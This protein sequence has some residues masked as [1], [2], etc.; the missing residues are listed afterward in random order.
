MIRQKTSVRSDEADA[1]CLRQLHLIGTSYGRLVYLAGLRNPDTGRYEHF[2]APGEDAGK[3]LKRA[4][5]ALFRDWMTYPLERKKTDI[6]L[7]IAGIT[8]VDKSELIDA[9]LRLTPYKN[10]VP[11][12]IQ[13]PERQKH[14]SDFEAIL[15]LLRN[16]YGVEAPPAGA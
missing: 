1:P 5:E 7:Y 11:A 9:W 13:G 10:L 8:E 12:S 2:G 6:E 16:V 4:H 3:L 14:I 15:G